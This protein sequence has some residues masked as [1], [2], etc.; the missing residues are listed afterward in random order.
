MGERMRLVVAFGML[1]ICVSITACVKPLVPVTDVASVS[2]S[3]RTVA[4]NVQV[5][6]TGQPSPKVEKVVSPL[7]AY[8]CK[9]LLWD[10]PASRGNALEQLQLKAAQA[11]ANALINV[12]FD[13]RGEDTW[14]T[15]CWE[16]V[17]ASGTAVRI[18]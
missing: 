5:F 11:G 3:D 15:N 9:N 18:K 16:S 14:G 6:V 1:L 4:A 12:T 13:V 17:Q 10:P 2:P 7:T 8:S